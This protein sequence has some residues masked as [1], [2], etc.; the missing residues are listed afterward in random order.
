VIEPTGPSTPY[1][2]LA[3]TKGSWPS[4]IEPKTRGSGKLMRRLARLLRLLG[5]KILPGIARR[6]CREGHQA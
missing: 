6:W 3:T 5:G 1:T 2:D 4:A